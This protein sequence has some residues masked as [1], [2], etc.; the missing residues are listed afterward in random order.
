MSYKFI[1]AN[2]GTA[3]LQFRSETTAAIVEGRNSN[4]NRKIIKWQNKQI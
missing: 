4:G 1:P 3:Q 2:T